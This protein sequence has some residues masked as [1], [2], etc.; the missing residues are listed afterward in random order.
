MAKTAENKSF[1]EMMAR[2]EEIVNKLERGDSTLDEAIALYTE[3]AKLSSECTKLLD[4]AEKQIKLL[5]NGDGD[6]KTE[7]DF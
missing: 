3:G 2:L 7:T 6:E 1:E 5:V 4:S